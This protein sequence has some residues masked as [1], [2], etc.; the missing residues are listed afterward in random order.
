VGVVGPDSGARMGEDED[1]LDRLCPRRSLVGIPNKAS[2]AGSEPR[3]ARIE[4]GMGACTG[5]VGK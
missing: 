2:A 3:L 5:R 1:K 4:G